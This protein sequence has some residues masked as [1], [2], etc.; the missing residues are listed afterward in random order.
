MKQREAKWEKIK[1][2]KGKRNEREG[3]GKRKHTQ[4]LSGRKRRRRE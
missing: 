2:R 4:K 1:E 3:K